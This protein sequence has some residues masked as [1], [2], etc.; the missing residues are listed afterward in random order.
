MQLPIPG[1]ER[2]GGA[3]SFGKCAGGSV[4]GVGFVSQPRRLDVCIADDAKACFTNGLNA[5]STK[6]EQP[7]PHHLALLSSVKT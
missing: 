4:P 6:Q 7:N 2:D 3:A 1:I 5:C